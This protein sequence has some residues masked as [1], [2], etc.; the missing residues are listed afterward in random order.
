MYGN[1][2]IVSLRLGGHKL[3]T[4]ELMILLLDVT[5]MYGWILDLLI[6]YKLRRKRQKNTVRD[7]LRELFSVLKIYG[8]MMKQI[9]R[10][11]SNKLFLCCVSPY[12]SDNI[13]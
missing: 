5:S 10:K 6:M 3:P 9:L 2:Y 7:T 11:R 4:Y 8:V 1:V 13:I 12:T